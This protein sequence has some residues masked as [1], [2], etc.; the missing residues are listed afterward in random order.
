MVTTQGCGGAT[1]IQW[2]EAID[3]AKHATMC[4]QPLVQNSNRT[5]VEKSWFTDNINKVSGIKWVGAESMVAIT[6]K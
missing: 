4:R 5:E 2:V 6:T 1:G 3:A